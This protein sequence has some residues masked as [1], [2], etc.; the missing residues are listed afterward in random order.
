MPDSTIITLLTSAGVAGVFCVLFIAGWVVP[1]WVVTDLKERVKLL[2]QQLEAVNDR[3]NTAQQSQ[4]TMRDI[5][6]ALT[7]GQA[8]PQQQSPAAG[9]GTGGQAPGAGS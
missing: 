9:P 7:F 5:L 1:K 3:A 6:A 8:R 4:V 2:E